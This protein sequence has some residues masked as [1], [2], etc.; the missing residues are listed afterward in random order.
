[1]KQDLKTLFAEAKNSEKYTLKSG[2]KERFLALLEKEL[3]RKR[4]SSSRF[5]F[6]FAASVLLIVSLGCYMYTT[7]KTTTNGV[8]TIE[9]EATTQQDRNA[10][11]FSL[12]DLSPDLKK[13]EQY[14]VANINI[15]LAQLQ[16]SKENKGLVDSFMDRLAEL[17]E[18]YQLLT[19]E[20]NTLGPNDQTIS[21]LIQNLQLRLQL[22]QKLKEKLNELKSSKNETAISI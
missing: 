7:M 4:K 8:T 16:I 21:A 2:H 1:M 15:E 9:D 11:G 10:E 14:Y 3:P 13:V 5:I 17:N 18:E 6:Q 12:G 22:L 19:K 20:L